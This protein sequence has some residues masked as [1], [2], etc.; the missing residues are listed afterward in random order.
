MLFLTLFFLG[1]CLASFLNVLTGRKGKILKKNLLSDRSRCDTCKKVLRWWELI[2]I[3]SWVALL[4]RCSR[5]GKPIP[6]YNPLSELLLGIAFGYGTQ[7]WEMRVEFLALYLLFVLALYVFSMYDVFFRLVPTRLVL[8][9]LAV[10]VVLLS[11]PFASD[12]PGD[13]SFVSRIIGVLSFAGIFVLINVL[14]MIGV[15]PGVSKGMQ[16][17]GWGDAKL[18][19]FLGFVL[20]WPLVFVAFWAAVFTGA[21]MGIVVWIRVRK[22]HISLPFVP[23]LAIGS[24]V[25]LLWGH[26]IMEWFTRMFLY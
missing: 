19:V 8:I 13:V 25:A 24:W 6:L 21:F 16:G 11:L 20:G 7:F 26:G 15:F 23:F 2:P 3:L 1:A 5:C 18:A 14:T 10:W 9:L 22:R 12:F 17:F 4:G